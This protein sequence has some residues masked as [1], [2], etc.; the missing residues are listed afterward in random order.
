MQS[1]VPRIKALEQTL[2]QNWTNTLKKTSCVLLK[3]LK[4][5][6]RLSISTL[7]DEITE[8]E[9]RLRTN[10]NFN[11]HWGC[12]FG[13]IE[14]LTATY[15]NKKENKLLRLT[16]NRKKRTRRRKP[17]KK[18]NNDDVKGTVINISNVALSKDEET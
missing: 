4:A 8:L 1:L 17:K 18:I 14:N 11:Q 6:H 7:T 12:I 16:G 13:D 9:A 10:A 15:N 2:Q 5:F 3:H